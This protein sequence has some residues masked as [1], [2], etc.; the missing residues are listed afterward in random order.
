MVEQNWQIL[1]SDMPIEKVYFLRFA[2]REAKVVGSVSRRRLQ[3]DVDTEVGNIVARSPS[4]K[5]QG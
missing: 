1:L 3:I 5:R 2:I 4:K